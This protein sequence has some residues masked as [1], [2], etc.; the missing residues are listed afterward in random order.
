MA[1]K[2]A[3]RNMHIEFHTVNPKKEKAADCVYLTTD[4]ICQNKQS[5]Y[6]LAKCF[7]ASSCPLRMKEKDAR[8]YIT[9][10]SSTQPVAVK[11]E[12]RI[13]RIKC[14]I[15]ADCPVYSETFG[16]GKFVG[17]NEP[18]MIISIQFGTE[19]KRF[20]YPNAIL[21]KFLILPKHAF[22]RVL[23]DISKAEKG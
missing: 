2:F 18:S 22:E 8:E 1:R 21:E 4:R 9:K 5:Y 23:Y 3:G 11:R 15:P 12:P 13:K 19:V 10:K 14:T 6:Y 16:K 7:S 17:Y 20:Q